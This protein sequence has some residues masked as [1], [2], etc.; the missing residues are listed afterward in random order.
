MARARRVGFAAVAQPLLRVL[1]HGLQHPVARRLCRSAA[2]RSTTSSDLSCSAVRSG[3]RLVLVGRPAR[4]PCRGL[5][6][7]AAG[8]HRE[9]AQHALLAGR[10]AGRGST[11]SSRAASAGAGARE[12]PPRQQAKAVV[13]PRRDV[14][15]RAASSRARRRARS[16]ARCRRAAGRSR[17]RSPALASS[18]SKSGSARRARS[19]N[20]RTASARAHVVAGPRVAGRDSER[21][22]KS[23]SPATASG[24]RLVAR[25][26]RAARRARSSARPAPP[27]RVEH[28][29][30]V[31]QHDQRLP[32]GQMRRQALQRRASDSLARAPSAAA[33]AAA[34]RS[35]SLQRR[36]V[37]EPDAVGEMPRAA[38]ARIAAPAASCRSRRCR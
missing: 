31:V 30:A 2:P 36:E 13:E 7:A 17:R 18:T 9:L 35:A 25:I 1:A 5:E 11:A 20:R 3:Q 29:L 26:A 22:A 33:Q 21:T 38:A 14:V 15:D 28:V 16:P 23:C 34:T 27:R 4:P 37:D 6:R 19:T 8:K 24:S 32:R 10:R 12:L